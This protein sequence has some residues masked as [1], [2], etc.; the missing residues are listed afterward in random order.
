V[1]QTNGKVSPLTTDHWPLSTFFR[2]R[3]LKGKRAIVTGA[4]SGIGRAVAETLAR[5]G[6]KVVAAARSVD[7]L[8]SLVAQFPA[9]QVIAC[10]TDVT[11]SDQRKRLVKTAVDSFGG[12]DLI[13]NNAGVGAFGHFI[14]M[15]PD[16]L[17]RIFEVNF[18]AQA[19]LC[20]EAI[21]V[22]TNGIEPVIVNVSS[23]TGRR[24][25]PAW[26]DYSASKFAVC[27][28]SEAL[29]AEL[30]RFGIDLTLVVPG[31]TKSGL[32][33]S[34]IAN[35]G[36]LP[37]SFAGGL[38]PAVVAEQIVR[39]VE[40]CKNEVRIER[41]AKLLLFVN[42]LAPR[43]VDRMM[44]RIVKKLYRQ[45]IEARAAAAPKS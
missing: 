40:R 7:K 16:V 31:L 23:M 32:Q 21:P 5:R 34:L 2:R 27:G 42:W 26:T 8:Q 37:P 29:R 41:N 25:V 36:R 3:D 35:T 38:E 6:A 44:K 33:D 24:G 9:G 22:L 12:L 18:F 1:S 19:E 43:F 4:S 39:G 30:V 14:D 11:D 28:F 13:V 10:P 15:T 20:R 45:E 17:R